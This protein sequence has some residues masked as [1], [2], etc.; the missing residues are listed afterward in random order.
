ML[1]RAMKGSLL[2]IMCFFW[3]AGSGQQ[4]HALYSD[5]QS[6]HSSVSIDY[7]GLRGANYIPMRQWQTLIVLPSLLTT[8]WVPLPRKPDPAGDG[9]AVRRAPGLCES[10]T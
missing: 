8:L 9:H 1:W 3:G 7:S 5:L 2:A 10:D 6:T 4:F